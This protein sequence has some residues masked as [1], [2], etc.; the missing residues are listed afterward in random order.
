MAGSWETVAET[1]W[2]SDLIAAHMI[3]LHTGKVLI[4]AY[5]QSDEGPPI[6]Y[7]THEAVVWKPPA[8]P[9]EPVPQHGTN[10]FCSGHCQSEDGRAIT[11]GGTFGFPD[12]PKPAPVDVNIFDSIEKTWQNGTD[13]PASMGIRRYYPTCTA[14]P[15]GRIM[16]FAGQ[17]EVG[18]PAVFTKTPEVYL[19]AKDTWSQLPDADLL[20]PLYPYMFVMPN[21]H[22]FFAG[23]YTDTKELDPVT[24]TW[25]DVLGTPNAG[26]ESGS[27]VM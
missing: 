15:D 23:R 9:S 26:G 11:A 22:L 8:G 20:M 18:P 19:P 1:D 24:L 5:G 6:E 10:L 2:P 27:A 12:P 13:P 4:W 21:G 17:E 7:H 14:L 16:V 25:S 3:H